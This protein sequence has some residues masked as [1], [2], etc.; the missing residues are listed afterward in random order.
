[1]SK[2]DYMYNLGYETAKKQI[3]KFKLNNNIK[4]SY[5]EEF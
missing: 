2:I 1:M 4:W 3:R 5:I